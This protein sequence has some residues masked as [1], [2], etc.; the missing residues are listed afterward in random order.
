M[1]A[2]V[3]SSNP[4]GRPRLVSDA[5]LNKA[6]EMYLGGNSPEK[7]ARQVWCK[8]SPQT[9]RYHLTKDGGEHQVEMRRKGRK[10]MS[11]EQAARCVE[12]YAEGLTLTA[13]RKHADM[14]NGRKKFSL[15]TLSKALKAAGVEV[16]RGRPAKAEEAPEA[17]AE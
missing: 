15:P 9:L 4:V 5:V 13:I 2:E 12:L 3:S 6:R 17:S 7:I 8:V 14:K 1:S 16:K 11:E 10:G